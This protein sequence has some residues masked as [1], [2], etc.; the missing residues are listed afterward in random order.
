QPRRREGT[1][2]SCTKKIFLYKKVFVSSWLRGFVASWRALRVAQSRGL[3]MR[4][5]MLTAVCLAVA[6]AFVSTPAAQTPSSATTAVHARQ[7]KRLLIRNAMVI[8]GPAV[9]ASGPI[10]ILLEDGLIA[11]M[12]SSAGGRWPALLPILAIK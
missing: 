9:P 4:N 1:K 8:P 7:V 6:L 12:G 2:I 10:D 5:F 11:R 3:T